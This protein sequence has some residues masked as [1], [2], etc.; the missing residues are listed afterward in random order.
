MPPLSVSVCFPAFN[1]EG[2]V[3]DVLVHAH[4]ILSKSALDYEILVCDDGSKDRTP[5]ILDELG[6]TL[7]KFRVFHNP[8]NLG[9]RATFEF[10]YSQAQ[11][12]CVFLNS[13][14]GQWKTEILF[15][16]AP[17]ASQWDVIIASRRN[18]H[19]SAFRTFVSWGFNLIPRILFGVRTYDAGAVK[20]MKREII[21]RFMLVS[22]S[23]FTEA[24]RLI[25]AARA[26][27]RI[28]EYPVDI[29][30][31]RSGK[32]QGVRFKYVWVALMDLFRVFWAIRIRRR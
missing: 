28:T 23:P 15:D 19:Y 32:A 16:V 13:T 14:D 9:I 24:E 10:L 11:K 18:K 3:R 26:G 22:K 5:Q 31:R 17:M 21:T 29:A 4:E 1:E 2:T 7:P 8:K 27:Y 30:P 20:L 25:R 6:A 12:E